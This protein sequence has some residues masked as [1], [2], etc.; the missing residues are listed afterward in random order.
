MIC[1]VV[2]GGLQTVLGEL[3]GHV[4]RGDVAAALSRA[5]AFE[6]VVRKKTHVP[7]NV[8]RIDRLQGDEGRSRQLHRDGLARRSRRRVGTAFGPHQKAE[9]GDGDGNCSSFENGSHRSAFS[10]QAP[11][12]WESTES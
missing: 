12:A 11:G 5:A 4:F 6:Q 8:L 2:A 10:H 3:R 7:A 1:A 9:R